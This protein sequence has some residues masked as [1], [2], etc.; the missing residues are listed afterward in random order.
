MKKNILIV[1]TTVFAML[2]AACSKESVIPEQEEVKSMPITISAT[3]KGDNAKITYTESGNTISATW[4]SGDEILVAYDGRVSTLTLASGS[5]TTSATF[6]GTIY[7]THEP[8][9]NSI[10]SCY[11]KDQNN[12]SA[13]VDNGDGTIIY[14]DDAFL[15]QNGTVAGAGKCNTFFGMAKFGD[16]TD[17]K[18]EFS[19]NT[20]ILKFTALAPYGVSSGS[21]ATLTY[22]SGSATLAKS[23]FTV[24]TNGKTVVYMAVPAGTYS[25][26]QTIVYKSGETEI[27]RTLSAD[28]ATFAIG[29]TYSKLLT[30][31]YI[32][33]TNFSENFTVQDGDIIS[34]TPSTS[35]IICTIPNDNIAITLLN[36]NSENK[37]LY[38]RAL[39][40]DTIKMSG[41]NKMKGNP[42]TTIINVVSGKTITIKGPGS[43]TA[44]SYGTAAVIGSHGYGA[45]TACGNI[46]I[47]EGTITATAAGS[48]ATPIG[49]NGLAECGNITINGGTITATGG[50][51]A[52][53]IGTGNYSSGSKCGNI[54][55]A[56]GTV[57][58]IGG[59]G[60]AGIGTGNQAKASCGAITITSGVTSVTATKGTDATNSIGRGN[61]SS[62]CGT[63]SIG[64][65]T[66][67][68]GSEYQ[69]DGESYLATSPLNF[70]SAK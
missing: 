33:L 24:G 31:G 37:Y 29:Q 35:G 69:N 16:G 53:G 51:N 14:T 63:V 65:T 48:G 15:N 60:A 42:G 22:N 30:F 12:S 19:V 26:E 66:Y 5:G 7:Y 38:I 49:G 27:I 41:T 2:V 58:A 3:Y 34:G 52:A 68:N 4:Q 13:L 67:W 61:S 11:V 40:N 25:G 39:G 32:N 59:S 36:V 23:T 50:A 17:I 56:G 45:A 21:S 57:N 10:L 6:T 20:S 54:Y 62:T 44:T 8:S 1:A 46:I 55:I 9:E 18:C 70:P 43:L 47:N 64:G 28:H